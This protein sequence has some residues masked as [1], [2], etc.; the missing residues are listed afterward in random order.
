[1]RINI[2]D[3]KWKM[4]W[5]V[6]PLSIGAEAVGTIS[7][8]PGQMGALIRLKSGTY[9]QGNAGVIKMVDQREVKK[10]LS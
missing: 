1:M 9:V 6:G 10:L 7:T 4:F 2:G 5:G 3:T 8:R